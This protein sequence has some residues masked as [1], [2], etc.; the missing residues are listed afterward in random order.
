MPQP[1]HDDQH[2]ADQQA[3]SF[4]EAFTRLG[5]VAET[6][7]AGGLP[8]AQAAEL[9][10][11]G[12]GLA[13]RCSQLLEA[14]ELKIAEVRE[15]GGAAATTVNAPADWTPGP[16]LAWEDIAMSPADDEDEDMDFDPLDDGDEA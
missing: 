16:G 2:V 11:Q 1:Q 12:M 5:E 7:E 3:L 15:N 10:E 8:L 4:E 6:L 13:R 14:T 9:Y